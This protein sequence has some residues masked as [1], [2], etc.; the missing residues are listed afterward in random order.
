MA[1]LIEDQM[2]AFLMEKEKKRYRKAVEDYNQDPENAKNYFF[3]H[4][5]IG[6]T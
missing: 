2:H 4:P 6:S 3:H 5:L 1:K